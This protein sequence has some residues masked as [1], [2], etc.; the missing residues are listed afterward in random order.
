MTLGES[1]RR[2]SLWVLSGSM[3][4]RA[5]DF[6]VGII[7][8]RLLL[9]EDFGLFVTVGILTGVLGFIAAGGMGE[10]LVR[11]KEIDERD[12]QVVFT[13]QLLSCILIFLGLQWIAPHFAIWFDD[14][15]YETLLRV[16]AI[17]FLLRPFVNIPSVLLRREMRFKALS[18]RALLVNVLSSL[19]GILLALLGFGVW[20]LLLSGLAAGVLNIVV[21]IKLSGWRP[22]LALDWN[23]VKQFGGIG[24]R[25][26][27]NDLICYLR[28][29]TSM[30]LLSYQLGSR[31]VGLFN[32]ADNLAE[33][34]FTLLGGAAYQTLFRALSAEQ[35]NLDRSAYLFLRTLTM[36][37]LYALPIYIGLIWVAESLVI[38][39]YGE[40]WAAAV[41]PLQILATTGFFRV[42]EALSG[43]VAAAQN[44]LGAEIVI[45]LENWGLLL[46]GCLIGLQ[47]G[48]LGVAI[49]ILPSFW[50]IAWRMYRLAASALNIRPRDLGR[51]L[52]PVIPG[53]SLLLLTLILTHQILIGHGLGQDQGLYLLSMICCS[54]LVYGGWLLL[55]PPSSLKTE[56]ARWRQFIPNLASVRNR[57]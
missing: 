57:S 37:C 10:A 40:N 46:I 20:S 41:L 5:I 2:N 51:A 32:K 44:C 36:V 43:A 29:R 23:R 42:L 3:G 16:S 4:G 21:L 35:D 13:M 14:P 45:Q 17:N 50:Y 30:A 9:P 48:T 27:A 19:I 55:L 49:G 18:L 33:M 6:V 15:L 34:P 24:V 54:G 52:L 56:S 38:T 53:N 26:T 12:A 11:A 28:T 7:L 47:W 25:F 31:E 39:L 22:R 1:I 8:A